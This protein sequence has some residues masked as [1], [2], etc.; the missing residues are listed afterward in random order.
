MRFFRRSKK[1]SIP[2]HHKT[3]SDVPS[4]LF[5]GLSA[6]DVVNI[7]NVC[8]IRKFQQD[9]EAYSG[10]GHLTCLF[11]V[12]DGCV[13]FRF[14]LDGHASSIDYHQGDAFGFTSFEDIRFETYSITAKHKST[15]ME[16]N[17]H[18]FDMF[19]HSIKLYFYKKSNTYY[20]NNYFLLEKNV[21]EL[22]RKNKKIVDYVSYEHEKI[23]NINSSEFI[24]NIIKNIPKLPIY[25]YELTE[26]LYDENT[27]IQDIAESIHKDP[28]L[29][30]FILK[31]VNSS[32]Y[33]LPQKIHDIYHAVIFLGANNI[34]QLILE[35]AIQ[36]ILPKSD[37]FTEIQKYSALISTFSYGIA[38]MSNK[39][40]PLMSSTIGLLHGIGSIVILLLKR[41]YPNI[42]AL[43]GLLDD[44]KIAADLLEMW[45]LPSSIY[46]VIGLRERPAFTPPEA[47]HTEY[48]HEVAVL[49][50][51]RV[52]S[53]I[54]RDQE[55]VS[56][57]FLPDYMAVLGI[58]QPSIKAFY[59]DAL[60]PTLVRDRKKLPPGVRQ[61]LQ[62]QCGLESVMRR[63]RQRV[64]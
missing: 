46:T 47:L 31:T 45:G 62:E 5:D 2:T 10:T 16:I 63:E 17:Q 8:H 33:G 1:P 30:S 19:P 4:F 38:S 55:P 52:C 6:A 37:E 26:K 9:Q 35:K 29:A 15:V 12:T 54:L 18:A 24:Q 36:N 60:L 41:K 44:A 42:S 23:E 13:R 14:C 40:K 20:K 39:A 7:Y 32:Y 49:Y 28:S 51:A 22:H 34:Y 53:D 56:E 3:Q 61:A 25:A 50:V 64:S 57:I 59:H 43:F 48:V 58:T 21:R 27:Q 11:V